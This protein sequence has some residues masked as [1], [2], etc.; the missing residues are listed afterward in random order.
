MN[1]LPPSP[2]PN[3]R[4]ELKAPQHTLVY[5]NNGT[6]STKYFPSFDALLNE[7]VALPLHTSDGCEKVDEVQIHFN[8]ERLR[9]QQC[10][11]LAETIGCR[12]PLKKV[13]IMTFAAVFCRTSSHSLF[14]AVVLRLQ[15][16]VRLQ[17]AHVVAHSG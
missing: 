2:P 5:C 3:P 9:E 6:P 10:E 7:L 13:S 17:H 16:S 4:H 8:G 11:K 1:S 15:L 14:P 12:I